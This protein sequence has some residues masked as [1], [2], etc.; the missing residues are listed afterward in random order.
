MQRRFVFAASLAAFAL[1]ALPAVA[2]E[3]AP[4][5]EPDPPETGA[6]FETVPVAIE[7]TMGTIVIA[8]ETQRAPV[9]S[10]NFLKYADE[11]RFDGTVFYRAMHLEWGGETGG[12][13]Q[14]GTQN[15]PDRIL[16]PIAHEATN[17]TGVKHVT[18]AIS[19]ARFAPGSATGDFSIMVSDMTG[20]DADLRS[21]NP[22]RRA[23]FAAFGNVVAG[24][25]VVRA[26]WNA[27][28][29]PDKGEGFLKGEMIANPVRILTV[30]RVEAE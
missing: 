30:R 11:K 14:G 27:P 8:L 29:D 17:E 19:M 9:T 28:I 26:I 24:M 10:A 22:D 3:P 13:I 20:L 4:R 7:T 23:G 16:P 5:H 12:L 2:Q 25:D 1:G 18:G 21:D 6:A 15:H